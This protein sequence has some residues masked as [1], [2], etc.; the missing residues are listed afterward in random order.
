MMLER[1]DSAAPD[2]EEK[3]ESGGKKPVIIYILVL[4]LVAFLLMTLSLLA[5]Q[6]SN[7]EAIGRLQGS[8]SAM[9]E[10]QGLQE[11][12]IALQK[13]LSEAKEAAEIFEDANETSRNQA[14]HMEYL[15][16]RTQ[17]AAEWF[18]QL[19]EACLREDWDLC[20]TI[21]GTM[22][23]NTASP[24]RDYLTPLAAER[25]QEIK[26]AAEANLGE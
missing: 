5:H 25:Y 15:L 4:F 14:S 24:M 16:E 3:T 20:R 2:L 21:L 19:D 6:R 8:V 1:R 26:A 17:E 13:E 22:E 7:T 9:Q 10:V 23:Q 12:V 18:W 11:Q